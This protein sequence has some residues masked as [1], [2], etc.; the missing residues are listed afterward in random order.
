[1]TTEQLKA[2]PVVD[3]Y[4]GGPVCPQCRGM[5]RTYA[6]MEIGEQRAYECGCGKKLTIRR[7]RDG[8]YREAG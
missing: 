5:V 7:D 4:E 8:L 2:A 1:M 6:P 3:G